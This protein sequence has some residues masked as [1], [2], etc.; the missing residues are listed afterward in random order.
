MHTPIL[1]NLSLLPT[2]LLQNL[3]LNLINLHMQRPTTLDHFLF[4]IRPKPPR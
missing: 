1:G 3:I 2:I 4:T